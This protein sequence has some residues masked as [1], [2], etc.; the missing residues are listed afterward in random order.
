M[1]SLGGGCPYTYGPGFSTWSWPRFELA[2][3]TYSGS[4]RACP[5]RRLACQLE[6]KGVSV[7]MRT[8][9]SVQISLTATAGN[10]SLLQ[11][12]CV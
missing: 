2:S 10:D 12:R 4:E 7:E 11:R 6:M 3:L 5:Y 8:A 1:L 9:V